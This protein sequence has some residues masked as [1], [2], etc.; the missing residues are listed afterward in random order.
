[1]NYLNAKQ[2]NELPEGAWLI[3]RM[4]YETT[5]L[6]G[7]KMDLGESFTIYRRNEDMIEERYHGVIMPG[8]SNGAKDRLTETFSWPLLFL[9][10]TSDNL[11]GVAAQLEIMDDKEMF[12]LLL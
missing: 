4:S 11:I 2:L 5:D 9:P 6:D 8:D 10:T 1:M 12:L 7:Y 3:S